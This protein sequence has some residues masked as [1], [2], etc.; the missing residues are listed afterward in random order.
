[1]VDLCSNY[2]KMKNEGLF[3]KNSERITSCAHLLI[4][5]WSLTR[6]AIVD[7]ETIRNLKNKTKKLCKHT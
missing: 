5:F 4:K 2:V 7:I 6:D 3:K 1:M